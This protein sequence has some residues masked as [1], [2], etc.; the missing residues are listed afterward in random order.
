MPSI[1][2][3][4]RQQQAWAQP[5][6][7]SIW[8]LILGIFAAFLVGG[9]GFYSW[10]KF[11]SST[12]ASR[13]GQDVAAS[14]EQRPGVSFTEGKR[15][16]RAETA[17]LLKTCV[18][19]SKLGLDRQP[20]KMAASDIYQLLQMAGNMTRIVAITGIKQDAVDGR[21]TAYLWADVA[22]C[23]YRQNGWALCDPDN[24]ALAVEAAAMLSR[25]VAIAPS[26]KRESNGIPRRSDSERQYQLQTARNIKDRVLSTV[27]SRIEEGYLTASDF[28]ILTHE[29]IRR[30]IGEATPKQNACA[31]RG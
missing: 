20:N 11:K 8:P 22:D 6:K 3:Q 16:G 15:I 13:S 31:S 17:P 29:D 1:I 25:Q 24:R 12:P 23:V 10:T 4:I 28:G 27:R 7:A 5:K 2:D 21:D 30:T 9:G 26:V 18:P 19:L 14:A